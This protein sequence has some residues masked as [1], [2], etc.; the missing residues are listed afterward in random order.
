MPLDLSRRRLA[1]LVLGLAVVA[2]AASLVISRPR[3][4]GAQAATSTGVISNLPV[5]ATNGNSNLPEFSGLQR[6]RPRG[7]LHRRFPSRRAQYSGRG[8]HRAAPD[9]DV[10][11]HPAQHRDAAERDGADQLRP[12][13][14]VRETL[15]RLRAS[16]QPG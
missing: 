8:R 3:S 9:A 16:S 14:R 6:R 13:G 5:L 15:A 10:S 1:V 7:R 11:A 4:A 12:G 2:L